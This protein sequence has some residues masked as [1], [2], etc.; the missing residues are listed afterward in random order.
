V[1]RVTTLPA[2]TPVIPNPRMHVRG[3][4][5]SAPVPPKL[6]SR[7]GAPVSG[8]IKKINSKPPRCSTA[9]V[10]ACSAVVDE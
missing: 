1:L 7:W 5:A 4:A 2:L 8:N 6:W 3:A 10:S 9:S